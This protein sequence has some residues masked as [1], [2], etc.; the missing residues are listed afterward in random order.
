MAAMNGSKSMWSGQLCYIKVL[1]F[2]GRDFNDRI[3]HCLNVSWWFNF[4]VQAA[5]GDQFSLLC[6]PLHYEMSQKFIFYMDQI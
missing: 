1:K 6:T 2:R 3:G 4:Y 5:S